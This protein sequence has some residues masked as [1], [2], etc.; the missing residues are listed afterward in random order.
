[1]D[2][3]TTLLSPASSGDGPKKLLVGRLHTELDRTSIIVGALRR[4]VEWALCDYVG[5]NLF[6]PVLTRA[7]ATP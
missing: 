1:M 7:T 5:Y 3:C 6:T 4:R 2:S